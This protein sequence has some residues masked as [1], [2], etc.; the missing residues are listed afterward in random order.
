M[1]QSASTLL[2]E[3]ANN[4]SSPTGSSSP[5]DQVSPD[6]SKTSRTATSAVSLPQEGRKRQQRRWLYR[7]TTFW[8]PRPRSSTGSI[9]A[10]LCCL[11]GFS[12]LEFFLH[13]R[14]FMGLCYVLTVTGS[15]FIFLLVS[16][17]VLIS[18]N[19]NQRH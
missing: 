3:C 8:H 5:P 14:Y 12:L 16:S 17:L 11:G 4:P 19:S 1:G 6:L 18:L 2:P 15:L 13:H 9:E 10:Q 7:R